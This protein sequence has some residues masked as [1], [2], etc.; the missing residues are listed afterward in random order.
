MRL[1][2]TE[3]MRAADHHAIDAIGIPA[4]VLM[5]N[6]GLKSLMTMEKILGGLKGKRF[7]I[8]CGRGNNGG[9]G[10]VIARHLINNDVAT[11]VFVTS[12]VEE[13]SHE[14]AQNFKILLRSG[15]NPVM[16]RTA[17]DIDRLRIAMEFSECI[18]DCLYGTGIKGNIE[19]VPADIIRAMNESRAKKI[20][21]DL[22]SG[23]CAT[24]GSISDPTFVADCTICLG[25]PKVGLFVFPGKRFAGEIWIADI[26]IPAVSTASVNAAHFLV[27]SGLAAT[28]IPERDDGMHKGDAGSMIIL[29]GSDEYHGAGVMSSYGAMRSG[30]GIVTLGMPDC[31][32]SNLAC[33]VLPE[34]ITRF[35]PAADG[36]FAVSDELADRLS[37]QYRVMLAGPGWDEVKAGLLRRAHCYRN[38]VVLLFSMLTFSI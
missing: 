7:T 17:A 6:A 33:T 22:P 34:V 13:M 24:T 9:D 14:A 31:L 29:A 30:A 16:L 15:V 10:L 12:P 35:F 19:G 11:H 27:T 5:E 20:S 26:G 38:G 8:V 23:L 36:G 1:Y 25:L 37:A 32:R 21:I 18:V 4:M 3:E 2:T 28:L